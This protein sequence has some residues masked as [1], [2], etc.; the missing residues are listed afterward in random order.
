MADMLWKLFEITT[1]IALLIPIAAM[2]V[3]V[4]RRMIGIWQDRCGPNR[5]GPFGVLQSLAD[6][7]K[8]LGKEDWIPPFSD[9]LVFVLAPVIGAMCV[10]MSFAVVPFS[11]SIGVSDLNIGLL[12]F[13]AM[14]SLAVYSVVLAGWASNSKYALLGGMRAAAQTVS[15]EVFMGLSVMGVVLLTG[16]F[17][18]REIVLAQTDGWL[19]QSQ[20]VG[21]FI[22]LVAGIAESHRLPFDLP[23]AETELTAGFHTEYSG[24]KFAL[25][26]LGEYLSVTLISAMSVVLFFGGWLMPEPLASWLPPLLWFIIKIMFFVMFFILLRTS[27]PR[28]RFDQL[29]K[30][31]WVVMLPLALLNLLVTAVLRLTGVL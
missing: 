18:L 9:R 19:I 16:S 30:F 26:F 12:F 8:I 15:Y 5:V 1:I 21:F 4:E 28:P 3:W 10:L 11:P 31:G 25:F 2:L 29:L 20:F 17:N 24:L 14:A 27:L 6:L 13:L 23:E 7:L 22:F